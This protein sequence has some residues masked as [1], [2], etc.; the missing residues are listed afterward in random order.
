MGEQ[1]EPGKANGCNQQ[2]GPPLDDINVFRIV[3]LVIPKPPHAPAS[4]RHLIYNF[5]GLPRAA[6]RLTN[7]LTALVPVKGHR[8]SS[9]KESISVASTA[10]A[11]IHMLRI[12]L[13][14]HFGPHNRSSRQ[15][16][17]QPQAVVHCNQLLSKRSKREKLQHC[18]IDRQDTLRLQ[19]TQGGSQLRTRL[20]FRN[21]VLT[22]P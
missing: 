8:L 4:F 11:L 19:P 10:K 22:S 18:V 12:C 16:Q 3:A 6:A 9:T 21:G 2:E 20:V 17:P 14:Q 5:R 1:T 13:G 15:K 7:Q